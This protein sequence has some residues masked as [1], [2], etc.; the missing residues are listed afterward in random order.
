MTDISNAGLNASNWFV[1]AAKKGKWDEFIGREDIHMPK[2]FDEAH[3][4]PLDLHLHL[5]A[6]LSHADLFSKPLSCHNPCP[7]HAE[8]P[9]FQL[10]PSNLG[11]SNKLDLT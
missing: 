9:I 6:G 5:H 10:M 4:L 3:G 8:S 7:V 11:A 1:L 2:V